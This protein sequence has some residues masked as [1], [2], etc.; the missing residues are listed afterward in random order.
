MSSIH[1]VVIP[2]TVQIKSKGWTFFQIYQRD[3]SVFYAGRVDFRF[4][5]CQL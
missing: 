2:I 3:K 1:T 5:A 4:T